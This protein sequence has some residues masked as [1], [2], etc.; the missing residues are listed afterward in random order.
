MKYGSAIL[1]TLPDKVA[2]CLV[3]RNKAGCFF[4]LF[5]IIQY[6]VD[7]HIIKS[8]ARLFAGLFVKLERD[9]ERCVAAISKRSIL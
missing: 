6:A 7:H 4:G 5:C 9:K 2:M 3:N 1:L 8:D